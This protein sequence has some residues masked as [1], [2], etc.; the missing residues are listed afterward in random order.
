MSVARVPN[1]GCCATE[2]TIG[3]VKWVLVTDKKTHLFSRKSG[4]DPRVAQLDCSDAVIL[5]RLQADPGVNVN[6]VT[7]SQIMRVVWTLAVTT[8]VSV[9]HDITSRSVHGPTNRRGRGCSEGCTPPHE[10][11][12]STFCYS[13]L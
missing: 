4:R 5:W 10:S 12:K 9:T 2:S 6:K 13:N 7:W 3:L 8:D 1:S 11:G